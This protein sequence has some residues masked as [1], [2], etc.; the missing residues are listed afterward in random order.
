MNAHREPT[1]DFV[2]VNGVRLHTLDWG[3]D[4]PALVFLAG[5][6]NTP[7]VFD[8]VAKVLTDRFHV[9]GLTRRSHGESDQPVEGYDIPTLGDDVIGYLDA[10]GIDRASFVGHS[11][12]GH[13][14]CY[15][16]SAHPDR[17]AKLVFIGILIDGIN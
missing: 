8:A 1:G 5:Y 12:A 17:V 11:F 13:E 7:H 6:A 4:G 16:A 15:L 2:P 3:G 10:L 14:L 9:L